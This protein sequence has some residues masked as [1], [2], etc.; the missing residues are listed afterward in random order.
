MTSVK[1]L[2]EKSLEQVLQQQFSKRFGASYESKGIPEIDTSL[3]KHGDFINTDL[4][5][6]E[7]FYI[8]QKL[9]EQFQGK[10]LQEQLSTYR[11]YFL[12]MITDLMNLYKQVN[13]Q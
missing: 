5:I 10:E 1:L 2:D 6:I 3:D 12:K 9:R 13:K 4:Y 8:R 7:E 11:E